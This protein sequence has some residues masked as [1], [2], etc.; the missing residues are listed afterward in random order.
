MHSGS[1]DFKPPVIDLPKKE[2]EPPKVKAEPEVEDAP[3]PLPKTLKPR[4]PKAKGRKLPSKNLLDR[5]YS[6]PVSYSVFLFPNR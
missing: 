5:Q 2:A 1:E 4:K 3:P 6:K